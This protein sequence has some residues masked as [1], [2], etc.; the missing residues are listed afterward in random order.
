MGMM[1]MG[2]IVN[3]EMGIRQSIGAVVNAEIR[4]GHGEGMVD[5][6]DMVCGD[7]MMVWA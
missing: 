3:A 2:M 5:G 7:G 6:M 4:Y 1:V